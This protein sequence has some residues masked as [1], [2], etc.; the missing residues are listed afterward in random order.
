MAPACVARHSSRRLTHEC[1][2][3]RPAAMTAPVEPAEYR[4]DGAAAAVRLACGMISL[5]WRVLPVLLRV[6]K[7]GSRNRQHREMRP[8]E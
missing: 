4:S 8:L 5:P 6:P 7:G 2:V 1:Q 3:W